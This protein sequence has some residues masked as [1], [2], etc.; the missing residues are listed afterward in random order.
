MLRIILT[1]TLLINIISISDVYA[2]KIK[3]GVK[4][5]VPLTVGSFEITSNRIKGGQIKKN[6]DFLEVSDIYVPTK[7]LTSGIDL[8]DEHIHDRIKNENV[9]VKNAKGKDGA[10]KGNIII[11]DVEKEFNFTYKV[12]DDSYLKAIFE[13]NLTEFNIPNLS[14]AGIGVEDVIKLE[15][16]LPYSK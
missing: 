5:F 4:I 7:K 16:T 9:V 15:V 2:E 11:R 10:G 12:L 6:G 1:I 3:K 14:Y 8:R 13:L